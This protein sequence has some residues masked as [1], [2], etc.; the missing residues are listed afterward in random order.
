MN[1]YKFRFN[2]NHE[3]YYYKVVSQN[4]WYYRVAPLKCWVTYNKPYR[5]WYS[6]VQNVLHKKYNS[7][8][9]PIS[10]KNLMLELL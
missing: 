4:E 9:D 1:Y 7:Y 6:F 8:P 3:Y 2:F 5:P 10:Y